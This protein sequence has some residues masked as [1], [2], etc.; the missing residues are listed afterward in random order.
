MNKAK[1]VAVVIAVLFAGIVRGEDRQNNSLV[2]RAHLSF[3]CFYQ[4][5]MSFT[6]FAFSPDGK[7]L[8]V[9][10]GEAIEIWD[11][12]S[13]KKAGTWGKR[14]RQRPPDSFNSLAYSADGKLLAAGGTRGIV[15]LW[16][17]SRGKLRHEIRAQVMEE[18][19]KQVVDRDGKGVKPSDAP[20]PVSHEIYG[21]ALSPDN[22]LVAAA[23]ADGTIHIADTATGKTLR[24]LRGEKPSYAV[25][26]LDAATLVSI[27]EPGSDPVTL[28][29]VRRATVIA[30]LADQHAGFGICLLSL[31]RDTRI[32]AA[33]AG[34]T[35]FFPD[36]AIRLWDLAA[37]KQLPSID[38]PGADGCATCAAIS[39]NGKLVASVGGLQR[40]VLWNVAARTRLATLDFARAEY[41]PELMAVSFSPDGRSLAVEAN[42]YTPIGDGSYRAQGRM[43]LVQI[44]EKPAAETKK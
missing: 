34:T 44:V 6:P 33:A 21:V 41:G 9:A 27:G 26:F 3:P 4:G 35:E 23:S 43:H 5:A 38:P 15:A 32:I 19:G 37:R 42:E 10:A 18:R 24:Y 36:P 16:D 1:T 12:A 2:L 30:R 7:S 31:A 22:Q 29:D 25:A 13:A 39:P 11:T 17:V 14:P 20:R 28:W 8:A 40:V